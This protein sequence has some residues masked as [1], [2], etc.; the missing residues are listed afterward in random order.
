MRVFEKGT[1]YILFTKTVPLRSFS[2]LHW[3]GNGLEALTSV[4]LY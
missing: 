4:F 1:L 2:V 3:T